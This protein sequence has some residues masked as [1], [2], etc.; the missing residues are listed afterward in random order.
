MADCRLDFAWVTEICCCVSFS[1][2]VDESSS[3]IRSPSFTWEPSGTMLMIVALPS[4]LLAMIAFFN[5]SSVP[6]SVTVIRNGPRL[7]VSVIN[8]SSR[9]SLAARKGTHSLT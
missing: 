1:V 4:T 8:P 9:R 3:Q 2:S 6:R 7:T 5:E